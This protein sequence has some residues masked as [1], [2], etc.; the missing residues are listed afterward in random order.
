MNG[1]L[2]SNSQNNSVVRNQSQIRTNINIEMAPQVDPGYNQYIE[3]LE[4][5]AAV[6]SSKDSFMQM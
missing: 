5:K 3:E 6:S 2:Q 4:F 1:T